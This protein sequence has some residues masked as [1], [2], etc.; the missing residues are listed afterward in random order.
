M[1]FQKGNRLSRG[2]PKGQPNVACRELKAFWHQFFES[3]DYQKNATKRVKDGKAPHLEAYL[4]A[5][6]YG[7]PTEYHHIEGGLDVPITIIHKH[8]HID[9]P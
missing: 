3:K 7:K 5:K 1:P 8:I 9:K 4:F 6:I 2:R